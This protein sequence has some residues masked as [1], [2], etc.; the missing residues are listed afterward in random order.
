MREWTIPEDGI[1]DPLA[2]EIAASGQR[3]VRLTWTERRIAAALIMARGGTS[4][5]V[6]KR[7]GLSSATA[8]ALTDSFTTYPVELDE[9]A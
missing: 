9:A 4:Y 2:V 8:R 1:I 3:R 7:L 5:Q 6:A